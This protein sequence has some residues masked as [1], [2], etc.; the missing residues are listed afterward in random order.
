M[1]VTKTEDYTARQNML[2][3]VAKALSH[4]AR[5]A[6]LD[7]LLQVNACIGGELVHELP[8]AQPTV[9][10]HLRELKAAGLIKGRIEGTSVNYCINAARWA[11]VQELFSGF[12]SRQASGPDCF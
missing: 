10:R 9:S 2:A 12:F 1:G 6:I 7:H 4:P 11:E 5:V 3:A 8:L